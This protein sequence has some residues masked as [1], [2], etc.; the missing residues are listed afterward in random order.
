MV[1]EVSFGHP[2]PGG[3]SGHG[4]RDLD[5]AAD[6][7][8]RDG[9]AYRSLLKPVVDRIDAIG[10]FTVD[11]LL[12][13]PRP[14]VGTA[15]YGER[16][17]ELGTPLW[18]M[19]FREEIAPAMLIG[20]AAHTIGRH[21]RLS[22]TGAGLTLSAT[23]HAA[24]WPVPVGGSQAIADALVA[25][26]EAHSGRVR[27]GVEV[28]SLAELDG[29]DATLLDVSAPALLRLGG[30]RL[31][32][33][34]AAALRR[35]RHGN[36]VSKVDMALD[37][38]I[39][40]T[41]PV[42]REAPTLHLGG[43][44]EQIAAAERE[45]SRGRVPARPYLS[46]VQPSVADGSGATT[47]GPIDDANPREFVGFATRANPTNSRGFRWGERESGGESITTAAVGSNRRSDGPTVRTMTSRV[48]RLA[49]GSVLLL[50]L[51]ACGSETAG[52]GTSTTATGRN[53]QLTSTA[54]AN[55][56]TATS[57]TSS[58]SSLT[59][60][61]A[62]STE[63]SPAT[64]TTT[65]TEAPTTP[66]SATSD[67]STTSVT[68]ATKTIM[69]NPKAADG[70]V[71]AGWTATPTE[72]PCVG[73]TTAEASPFAKGN[74]VFTCG[75]NAASLLACWT[76]PA[77]KVGCIQGTEQLGR[78]LVTFASD[79]RYTGAAEPNPAPLAV[80]LTDGT[81][82]STVGH[83]SA[84]HWQGR[85][86]WLYC[87]NGRMLLAKGDGTTS[88]Y[89]DK[90]NPVWTAESVPQKGNVAPTVVRVASATYAQG[91]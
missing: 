34:Y 44:R 58:D 80:E 16:A 63:T 12:R 25:D 54:G 60:T 56:S 5:R 53:T 69:L 79:I 73:V 46:V 45:V 55:E 15:I 47:P 41:D 84:N 36:G 68:T 8:G 72:N 2:L 27:T 35:F 3:R 88:G 21:P 87:T 32:D 76:F 10:E 71:A 33:K 39:P 9:K 51:A 43:T 70:S 77:G 89:F 86:G 24:G 85:N 14:P 48:H 29:Y 82:C 91:S 65:S 11:T 38:P 42:L 61:T 90:S 20:C 75:P 28:T 13:V 19:R 66:T 17:L 59:T 6:A 62:T 4:Y 78:K 74:G 18:G 50:A 26:L 37:G 67:T 57:T 31:P 7:I 81:T 64:S 23:A 49:A 30:D 40:W 52:S 83:D 22:M 1:P